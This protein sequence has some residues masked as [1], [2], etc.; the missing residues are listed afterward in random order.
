MT[1]S[2]WER[3]EQ[4]PNYGKLLEI[5]SLTHVNL[6]WLLTGEGEMFLESEK[7]QAEIIPFDTENYALIPLY[8]SKISAGPGLIPDNQ[9]EVQI[10]FK[11]SWITRL[12]DPRN[13]SLIYVE[14]DSMLPTLSPGDLVLVDHSRN[15]LDPNG[16][17]YAI[18][19]ENHIMV[20]RLQITPDKKILIISDNPVYEN[21]KVTPDDL[22][23]N[24][25]VILAI[26][27][28]V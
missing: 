21:F 24:G 5:A 17:I 4:L 19:L 12:G 6:N 15:Y 9:V 20:K 16:G 23:I 1:I 28:L 22:I 14:G 13:M 11:R 27:K 8:S 2:K 10:A 7:N 3:E 25:R 18:S 26:R